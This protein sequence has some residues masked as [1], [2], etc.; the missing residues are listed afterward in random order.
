MN[1]NIKWL[2]AKCPICGQQ[3]EYPES[4]YRPKTCNNPDCVQKQ[5]RPELDRIRR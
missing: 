5:L 3:F 1:D 2:K 4:I